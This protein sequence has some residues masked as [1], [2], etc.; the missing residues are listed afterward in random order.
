MKINKIQLHNFRA[1]KDGIFNLNNYSLLIGENN[2]GKSTVITAIRMFYED[3]GLKFND[4]RDFP[5]FKTENKNSWIEIEFQLTDDESSTLKDEYR[6]EENKLKVRRYFKSEKKELVDSKNSNI[7]AYEN[8]NLS[9]NYFYG[10]KNI[11]Q[12]KLGKVIFIPEISKTSDTLKFSGPSPLRDITNF[13]FSKIVKNSPSYSALNSAF[14]S[15]NEEFDKESKSDDFTL[16]SLQTDIN[17]DLKSWEVSFGL[18]INPIKPADIVKTLFSH[19]ITDNNLGDKEVDIASLGQ[20]VQRHLI[21]TL[22]KLTAKYVDKK[23][24]KK[25]DFSPNFTLI[26]FEEPEA[27]LHPTQQEQLNI[28][29]SKVSSENQILISTHSP[30]FVSKNIDNLTSI[31]KLDRTNGIAKIFQI[32]KS[33]L[34]DLL[35][36]NA[37]LYKHLSDLLGD[38]TISDDLKKEIRK[39]HLGDDVPDMPAKLYDESFKYF[40]WLDSER[41]SAF[42]AKHVIICE[43]ATEKIFLDFLI[44]TKWNDLK[45]K[46]MYFLDSLGK[47]N[48]HR[49]MNLFG[50]LGITHSVL[51]DS[52]DD[53]GVHDKINAFIENNKNS[54]TKKIHSFD[55]DFETFLNI[56]L[57]SRNDLKPL[58]IMTKYDANDIEDEKISELK[59]LIKEIL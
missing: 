58:N 54:F 46:Q 49:F 7:Y 48:I 26:L 12:T 53:K 17:D 5:K 10:A 55:K 14:D 22:L 4:A 45:S 2:S 30:I 9:Q 16:N 37:G 25:K 40:L 1:I 28:S 32:E 20:G 27:F 44:N 42:F 47:F 21:Y 11:S 6:I 15:F 56:S 29:L 50:K 19:Y 23:E 52:D 41:S 38:T 18:R 36:N 13:V 31:V 57:P 24:E 3:D 43:G 33:E 51:F 34:D 8:G 39:K 35:N 59:K